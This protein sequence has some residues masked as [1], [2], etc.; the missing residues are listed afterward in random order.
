MN[1][2]QK[3][4]GEMDK[5]KAEGQAQLTIVQA[6]VEGKRYI[7]SKESRDKIIEVNSVLLIVLERHTSGEY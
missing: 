3:P 4:V 2:E 1:D 6:G 7:T 5:G